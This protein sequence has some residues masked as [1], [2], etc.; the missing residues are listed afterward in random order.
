MT[1]ISIRSNTLYIAWFKN[2]AIIRIYFYKYG[3]ISNII[4]GKTVY[5]QFNVC[6]YRQIKTL[7]KYIFITFTKKMYQ[8]LK[9]LLKVKFWE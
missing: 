9:Y 2:E 3:T 5:E 4:V 1:R 8:T 6:I 7:N